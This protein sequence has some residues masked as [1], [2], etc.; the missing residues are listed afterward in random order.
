MLCRKKDPQGKPF[1]NVIEVEF[2]CADCKA[3]GDEKVMAKCRHRDYL[4]PE[5]KAADKADRVSSMY[6]GQESV[7]LRENQ[8]V[9]ADSER[10]RYKSALLDSFFSNDA[11]RSKYSPRV[12]Y[13][14]CD[15]SGGGDSEMAF[16]AFA[17]YS[18]SETLVLMMM[19]SCLNKGG[20]VEQ[21]KIVKSVI[22]EIRR[23]PLY[24][25][26]PIVMIIEAAP[27]SEGTNVATHVQHISRIKVMNEADGG[28]KYGV[29][30]TNLNT[31][32]QHILFEAMMV[33]KRLRIAEDL[34]VIN[35]DSR[36]MINGIEWQNEKKFM[37]E[38]LKAQLGAF[39]FVETQKNFAEGV[40][41]TYRLTGKVGGQND[42]LAV[43]V[44]MIPYWKDRFWEAR[45]KPEY[46]DFQKLILNV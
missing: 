4:K 39:R 20:T 12:I 23:K 36:P 7:Q 1:F 34:I 24:Q 28:R 3:T 21:N 8:G 13:L 18:D 46:V 26:V 14:S 27:A 37:L 31:V 32:Q 5:W 41:P 42:D 38:K 16:A 43:S 19:A 33:S 30:K 6:E 25:N 9:I 17:E 40:K 29:P 44:V 22:S 45:D 11:Y 15:P 10:N 2:L 35:N